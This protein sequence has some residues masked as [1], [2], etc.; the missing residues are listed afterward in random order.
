M[1]NV[2]ESFPDVLQDLEAAIVM[3]GNQEPTLLDLEVMDAFDAL[4]RR[5]GAE[6][7]QR[8]VGSVRLTPKAGVVYSL[9]EQVCE[10]RLGRRKGD[11]GSD[12]VTRIEDL[13][14]CLRRI[15]KSVKFWND[16]AGRQGYL[17]Y[18]RR[19]VR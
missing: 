13:L 17:D 4:I 18:V 6:L 14:A 1:D 10:W 12:A 16:Q 19:F 9:V 2:I 8:Q 3:A 5:Y 15:R 11:E 7:Q